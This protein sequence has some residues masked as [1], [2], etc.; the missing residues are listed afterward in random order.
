MLDLMVVKFL[1][2]YF[3]KPIYVFG[4][5]GLV[6]LAVS[7]VALV[8]AVWLRAGEAVPLAATPLPVVS[9]LFFA[10][11][12]SSLLMGLLAEM[13]VRTY[14]ESQHRPPYTVRESRNVEVS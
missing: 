12:I 4:G 14:F 11:G 2:R 1:E 5:V 8:A 7:F 3:A 13:T 6:S 9:A 10:L